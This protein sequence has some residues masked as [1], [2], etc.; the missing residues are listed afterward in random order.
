MSEVIATD[1]VHDLTQEQ[2]RQ[3]E[4][5]LDRLWNLRVQP[6]ARLRMVCGI[7]TAL[8]DAETNFFAHYPHLDRE[9][10]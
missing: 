5:E 9:V 10:F 3:A 1:K 6:Q 2:A 7:F 4:K 8:K